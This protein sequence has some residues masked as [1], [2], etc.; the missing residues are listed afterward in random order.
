MSRDNTDL[1]E[2]DR[3]NYKFAVEISRLLS[4]DPL[5][6][7]SYVPTQLAEQSSENVIVTALVDFPSEIVT[8]LKNI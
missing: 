8:I 2:A 5:L 3:T 4:N 7:T 6:K 1:G